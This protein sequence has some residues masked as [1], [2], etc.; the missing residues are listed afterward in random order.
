MSNFTTKNIM[1]QISYHHLGEI[2]A[3]RVALPHKNLE[4]YE[5]ANQLLNQEK[6]NRRQAGF[7]V[8]E[9]QNDTFNCIDPNTQKETIFQIDQ[10][11]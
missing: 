1:Y 8:S 11:E 2:N 5:T 3:K 10:F 9:I 6:D 4:T 7:Q